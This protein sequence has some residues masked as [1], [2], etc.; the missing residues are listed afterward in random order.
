MNL[1]F[2]EKGTMPSVEEIQ[3]KLKEKGYESV[4]IG[5]PGKNG[6]MF[7]ALPAITADLAD[8]KD[9]PFQLIITDYLEVKEPF[10]NE[11]DRS[12]FWGTKNGSELLDSCKWHILI[13][14]FMSFQH[15]CFTRAQ[16]NS[17]L[18]EIC[19]ELL[20]NCK[21]VWFNSSKNVMTADNAKNN[22]YSGA[23]R[24]FHG[25]VK[26]R[27]FFIDKT[28]EV[29]VDTIGLHAYGVAD[30]QFHF[31]QLN[32]SKIVSLA[33]DCA[34]YQFENNSPIENYHTIEGFDEL[35]NRQAEIHWR[36]QYEMAILEPER[37]VLDVNTGKIAGGERK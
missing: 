22:P 7:L 12:Q 9:E 14:D 24:I 29:I 17:D 18:L 6:T 27:V 8:R 11:T 26:E 31:K 35:G 23:L 25:A 20:P 21:A 33:L 10:G 32:V 4:S 19:L 3:S 36:C 5:A 1:L 30:M 34:I 2:E 15:N 28:D 37:M 16:I 13:G